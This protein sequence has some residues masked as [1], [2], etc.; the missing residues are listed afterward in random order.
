MKSSDYIVQFFEQHNVDTIFGYIGGMITHL[1]DSID[2]NPNV[3]YVQTYHE[4]TAAIAAEGYAIERD[5]IGVALSTSGPGATNMIT[6]IADAYFDSIP[7]VYITGQ[8]NSYEYK[9]DKPIRQQGF[10]ET[11]IIS[12]V[13]PVTKYAVLVDKIENLRYELEKAVSMATEG[14]KGPVVLDIP[15]DIQR[16]E[17]NPEELRAFLPNKITKNAVN[18]EDIISIIN[19]SER[20]MLLLGGGCQDK[21]TKRLISDFISKNPMPV[22]TSLMGKGVIDE[23]YSNYMGL[24]G[25]YGNR[26]AN[27][28][29]TNADLLI[30]L[31]SRLDTRQTG[32]KIDSFLP[33]STIIHVDIDNNELECHRISKQIKVNASVCDFLESI[34]S[35]ITPSSHYLKWD[36]YLQSIKST[37]SQKKEVERFVENKMPYLYMEYIND[38]MNPG[39]IVT[40]DVGQNQMWAAQSLNLKEGQ[41]YLTSGG[42]APMGYSMPSAI[43][44]AFSNSDRQIFS[45][46][47]D[48]GFHMSLQALPLIAQYNLNIKVCVMNNQA[49]GMITQFQHLYFD[50]RMAGTVCNGGYY[51]PDIETLAKAYGIEYFV[52]SENN[53]KDQEL[54]AKITMTRC[55][56]VEFKMDG[57]TTV[58]PKLE[59]DKPIS[60][61]TPQLPDEE[62]LKAM[63]IN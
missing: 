20:P 8:V 61:P 4:Q 49:L 10:Q 42:L 19:K 38:M 54:K 32:A 58:S 29:V 48:G 3:R 6:G 30:V 52:I 40:S 53:I 25:S 26:C 39:D 27:M 45:I 31:G 14:R 15:M 9:Y 23:T 22:I 56:L 62:Y 36:T 16:Q 21:E 34:N 33:D 60:R 59:Y 24:V 44:C 2:R 12:M 41:T 17:I 43:G 51:S 35:A 11:D 46:V 13:K 18:T 1:V 47:G 57:L 63:K 28:A 50:D 5:G 55:C 37:Y 7:V